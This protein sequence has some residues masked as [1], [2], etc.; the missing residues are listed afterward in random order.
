M[1]KENTANSWLPGY[2][3]G[4]PGCRRPPSPRRAGSTRSP[5][6]WRRTSGRCRRPLDPRSRRRRGSPQATRLANAPP[7]SGLGKAEAADRR[8]EARRGAGQHVQGPR[9][10]QP[11]R[12]VR[13]PVWI[14]NTR[15]RSRS[16]GRRP[17]SFA[18]RTGD[19]GEQR[20]PASQAR[21]RRATA[22]PGAAS[23][24]GRS[25]AGRR[26]S[27]VKSAADASGL[28]PCSSRSRESCRSH[29]PGSRAAAVRPDPGRRLQ[30]KS[31]RSA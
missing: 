23:A 27:A 11:E 29:R 10:G 14:R 2:Q 26:P 5:R 7:R 3:A 17:T 9:A 22:A 20:P 18:L 6:R 8:W 13:P 1:L 19:P 21:A 31:G 12:L 30:R 25:E 24:T 28:G 16:H 4:Q 15:H